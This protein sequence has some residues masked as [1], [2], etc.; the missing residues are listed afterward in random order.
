MKPR[1]N[2]KKAVRAA[3]P[4]QINDVRP[5]TLAMWAALE[6]IESPL[7][8]GEEVNSTLD[9][10]PSLYLLTHDPCEIF[11]ANILDLAMQWAD[12]V[13]TTALA[14]IRAAAERQMRVVADVIPEADDDSPKKKS[15]GPIAHL[16]SFACCE[17][18]WSYREAFYLTPLSVIALIHR[19]A[20]LE[21]NKIFPL[22]SIEEIDN[23][24]P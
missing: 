18:H 12:T 3:M 16:L 5:M 17:L 23:G 7:I 13:P 11:R 20:R 22:Q 15:D 21:A 24:H 10:I 19:R 2:P 8:T 4:L 1:A 14:E 9:L 6:H